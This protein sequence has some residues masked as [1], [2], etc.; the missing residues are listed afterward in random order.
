MDDKW[1]D[2]IIIGMVGIGNFGDFIM[3][4]S[5]LARYW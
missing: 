5:T 1:M 4:T 2:K 3:L